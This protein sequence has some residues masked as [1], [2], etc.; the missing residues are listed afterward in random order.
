VQV[1]DLIYDAVARAG[2]ADYGAV[3]ASLWAQALAALNRVYEQ[4]WHLYP[5]RDARLCGV[6]VSTAANELV[7]REQVDSIRQIRTAEAGLV[8]V[9]AVEVG[10]WRPEAWGSPGTPVEF[11]PLAGLAGERAAGRRLACY[12]GER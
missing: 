6:S 1:S 9:G 7:F 4:V 8:P 10:R 12:G 2:L 5:F 3:P 11:V